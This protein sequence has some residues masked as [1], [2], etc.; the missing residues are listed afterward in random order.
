[1]IEIIYHLMYNNQ[2]N[3]SLGKV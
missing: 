2:I 3:L 1:M